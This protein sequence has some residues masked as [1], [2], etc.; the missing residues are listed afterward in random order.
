MADKYKEEYTRMLDK[1]YIEKDGTPL[2]CPNCGSDDLYD[3]N[4][5]YEDGR[6]LV[7]YTVYCGDCGEDFVTWSYGSWS[8]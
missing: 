6:F 5:H 1:G 8:I 7:E 4:H 2:I 3:K